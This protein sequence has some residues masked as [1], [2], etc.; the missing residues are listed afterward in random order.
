[1]RFSPVL[2]VAQGL[3]GVEPGSLQ[4]RVPSGADP[5]GSCKRK[6]DRD[7]GRGYECRPSKGVGDHERRRYSCGNPRQAAEYRDDDCF[8][9][10]LELDVSSRSYHCPPDAIQ[11]LI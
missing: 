7:C 10:E 3:D 2:F 6:R 11:T 8:G 1:M 4:G 9:Q 5:D